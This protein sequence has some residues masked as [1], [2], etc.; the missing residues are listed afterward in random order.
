MAAKTLTDAKKGGKTD[1]GIEHPLSSEGAT[2]DQPAIDP[3]ARLVL[4][5][6]QQAW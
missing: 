2:G 6:L 4:G 1:I 5:G 3:S